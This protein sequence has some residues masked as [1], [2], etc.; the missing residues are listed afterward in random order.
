MNSKGQQK[1]EEHLRSEY[2]S[3]INH[4]QSLV[5]QG[6]QS[7]AAVLDVLRKS[8]SVLQSVDSDAKEYQDHLNKGRS[9]ITRMLTRD[10]TNNILLG[11]AVMFFLLAVLYIIKVRMT[12]TVSFFNVFGW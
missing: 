6:I 2:S 11:L 4:T 8:T 12:N 7:S 10:R 5:D 1:A 9:R 3:H